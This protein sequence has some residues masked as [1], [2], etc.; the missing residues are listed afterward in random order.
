MMIS[1][2]ERYPSSCYFQIISEFVS[3]GNLRSY[4]QA[5]DKKPF[6]W[7]LRL[8]FAVDIARA[9]A[10]LHARKVREGPTSVVFT[11]IGQIEVEISNGN[12]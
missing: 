1:V 4:I 5:R 11:K 9:L 8:S 3:G 7:R 6:P 12:R 10:Y 2:F